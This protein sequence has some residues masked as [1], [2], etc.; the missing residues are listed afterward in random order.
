MARFKAF[1]SDSEDD[2]STSDTSARS[3]RQPSLSK[4]NK[5]TRRS[6]SYTSSSSSSLSS[7]SV[8]GD[9]DGS[10]E[11]SIM[12]DDELRLS[13]DGDEDDEGEPAPWAQQLDL[14]PHRV[15]VM[16][17]S[18]FRVPE[19]AKAQ[20]KE[21][22]SFLKHRRSSDAHFEPKEVPPRASFAQPRSQPPPRKFVRVA[23]SASIAASHE[24]VYIDAGLSLGR[25]FRVGWGP[26]DRLVHVGELA[27]EITSY[28]TTVLS[29]VY[30]SLTLKHY[31][32]SQGANSSV[33]KI[34]T[35]QLSSTEA[36]DLLQH[37]L[38][39]THIEQP[40]DD[41]DDTPFVQPNRDLTFSSFS[42]LFTTQDKSHCASVFRLGHALFDPLQ[43]HLGERVPADIRNR[44]YDLRRSDA[45][46]AWLTRAVSSS[47][48]QDI[49]AHASTDSARIAFLHLTGNQVEKAV[50]CLTSGG[51][52]R[53]A[54]LISQVPGDIEFRA[55]IR[56]QMQIWKDE[57]VDVHMNETVRKLYALAAGE[58]EFLQGSSKKED[59]DITKG[60]DW[61]RVFGLQLWFSSFLDTPLRETFEVYEQLI[62]ENVGKVAAPTPWYSKAALHTGVLTDGLFNLIKLSLPS[63]ITLESALNPLSFSPN[64]RDYKVPWLLYI[65]LSRCL[66]VRDFNDRLLSDAMN[67]ESDVTQEI[68]GYSEV[69]DA[70]T[71]NFASQL[72]Q[73]G[74]IQEA[75]FVLLFLEDAIGYLL[76]LFIV[77]KSLITHIDVYSCP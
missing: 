5:P 51:N 71:V 11:D 39:H 40:S 9:S 29:D 66:R 4:P 33:I 42:S 7:E 23:S 67:D 58:A 19:L 69:A 65:L 47:V 55:D 36:P 38:S 21:N 48:E 77:N 26:G 10:E 34:T 57:K 64:P 45:L 13:P 1:A 46:S 16:Q 12:D 2:N 62:K 28:V 43:L 41:H 54:T 24:G 56:D 44:V 75:A 74:L 72:Q 76:I 35:P 15:H 25:S 27:T 70:L 52:I 20:Q 6:P 68:E 53:L 37:L 8:E 49:K 31:L 61:L 50:E 32:R 73:E 63:S 59:T 3:A 14:E 30:K 22:S 18:L 17:T 60:L